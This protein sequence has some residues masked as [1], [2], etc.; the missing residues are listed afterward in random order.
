MVPRFAASLSKALQGL[1]K[2][3]T[4][5]MWTPT[6]SPQTCCKTPTQ[7]NCCCYYIVCAPR[8][9]HCPVVYNAGRHLCPCILEGPHCTLSEA[10]GPLASP[11]PLTNTHQRE[12]SICIKNCV[13]SEYTVI[14][15]LVNIITIYKK[16]NCSAHLKSN[17]YYFW[18]DGPWHLGK[19]TEHGLREGLVGDVMLQK[20]HLLFCVLIPRISQAAHKVAL[21]T[22][23]NVHKSI[24][25]S[26]FL[27]QY[28]RVFLCIHGNN[29]KFEEVTTHV[30][31]SGIFGP[32]INGHH[33]PLACQC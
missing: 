13:L 14:D 24:N 31:V 23:K 12:Y 3:L 18:C 33:D 20:Q 25:S 2:W 16:K 5:A 22:S 21:T 30:W 7:I 32:A 27:V 4:S 15:I 29:S 19:E 9:F 28:W 10:S 26:Q 1:M 17:C 8:G 6:Y 11:C